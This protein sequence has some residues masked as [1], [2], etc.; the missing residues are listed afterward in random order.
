[1][2]ERKAANA[3]T[4]DSLSEQVAKPDGFRDDSRLTVADLWDPTL[5]ALRPYL[6]EARRRYPGNADRAAAA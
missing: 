5:R 1:M 3:S 2:A 4:D 6:E